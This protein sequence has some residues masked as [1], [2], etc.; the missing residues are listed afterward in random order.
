MHAARTTPLLL[1]AVAGCAQLHFL[2]APSVPRE[3]GGVETTAGPAPAGGH[4]RAMPDRH[5]DWGS[6]NNGYEGLR[7]SPLD[8]ITPANAR[9]L[10]P[11][12]RFELG[13]KAAMQSGPVV[14]DGTL[15]VTTAKNTYA[16]DATTCAL[17]WKHTYSYKPAPPFDL[18][19]NRGVAYLDGK[20][21]RGA[22]DGRVYALDARTGDE[23]W[24][25]AAGDPNKGETFPAA[26]VA[27]NGLVFIGNAGGDNFGV[28]GRMMAF[29]A[30]T[31]GR[32]W[33]TSLVPQSGDA[34]LTWPA[35]TEV[36]PKGGGATWTSYT[37]DTAAGL[38]YL[39]TGNAAPDFL[40]SVRPGTNRHTYSVLAL[41][42]RT[43]V[44]RHAY[45]ILPSD[46]HDWDVAAAPALFTPNGGRRLIVVGGKDGHLYGIDEKTGAFRFKTP[47]TTIDNVT[48][49]LTPEGT[50][51]CPGVNGGVEWN[52]P[53]ISAATNLAYVPS[54]DWCSTVA[55]APP[56]K[57]Q[58]KDGIP[59]TGSAKLR[60]P[61]GQPDKTRHGWLTAVNLT[62]GSVAWR[63]ASPTPLVAGVTATAGGVVMTGDLNGD[64]LV[65]DAG[66][67][68]IVYRYGLKQPIGGGVVS[69]AV[70]GRQYVA[71]AAGM[72]APLAWQL[73]SSP[74][75]VVV[76]GLR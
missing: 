29:D 5:A 44:I 7:F 11:L 22:N 54:I 9:E 70:N 30:Q 21:F 60:Q 75:T 19:V 47:V 35:A 50:R 73:K 66:S 32:V 55:I 46:F 14:V 25:V 2:K 24:N 43:G 68:S 10:S 74:A 3:R 31:G 12:C 8:E 37:I 36:V 61:F 39:S 76:F 20:L 59:W 57:L 64:F 45:Q 56:D 51:F 13:E 58:G 15:Y 42:A 4:L 6:Y 26:P 28:V 1:L 63:Y 18:K 38:I 69:Y 40:A 16:I 62:D 49:P 72:H 34:N 52:G 53:A 71:V 67:G 23:L 65:F 41:D 27:W 48:A 17:R 33:T